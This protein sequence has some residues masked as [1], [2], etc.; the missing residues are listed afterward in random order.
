MWI[1]TG[2]VG[3]NATNYIQVVYSSTGKPMKDLMFRAGYQIYI[4]ARRN[5]FYPILLPIKCRWLLLLRHVLINGCG[6][7][8]C[9]C[10]GS[11]PPSGSY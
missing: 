4:T 8:D 11:S 1:W 2:K 6:R 5:L 9:E 7:I 10:F 3:P